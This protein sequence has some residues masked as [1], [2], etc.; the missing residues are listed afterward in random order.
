MN[1]ATHPGRHVL[2]PLQLTSIFCFP[3][4]ELDETFMDLPPLRLKG[5]WQQ[6]FSP[7]TNCT[8]NHSYAC[9]PMTHWNK[10]VEPVSG[11]CPRAVISECSYLLSN[12]W[13]STCSQRTG[14][15]SCCVGVFLDVPVPTHWVH[16]LHDSAFATKTYIAS[17]RRPAKYQVNSL[18][19]FIG[20]PS[21]T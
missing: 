13:C 1:A 8:T 3:S 14:R 11:R 9:Q 5:K 21:N 17:T 10:K 19:S 15:A 4:E 18:R 20:V 12:H 2:N 16:C 7:S 6:T